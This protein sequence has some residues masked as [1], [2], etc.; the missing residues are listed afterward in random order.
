MRYSFTSTNESPPAPLIFFTSSSPFSSSSSSSSDTSAG[1]PFVTVV[2][3]LKLSTP[4]ASKGASCGPR[5]VIEALCKP[6][7]SGG[8]STRRTAGSVQCSSRSMPVTITNPLSDCSTTMPESVVAC[9]DGVATRACIEGISMRCARLSQSLKILIAAADDDT[10]GDAMVAMR[11][12]CGWW[13]G[14][15]AGKTKPPLAPHGVCSCARGETPSTSDRQLHWPIRPPF[16]DFAENALLFP[17]FENGDGA[18]A[19]D[20]S[21]G[22]PSSTT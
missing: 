14:K 5:T 8:G 18:N 9:G 11:G 16:P 1:F 10:K 2:A 12:V 20:T 19:I 6:K 17:V 4:A 15:V 13:P 21:N 3:M 22:L 7:D